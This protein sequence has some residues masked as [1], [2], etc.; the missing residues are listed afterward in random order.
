MRL[1]DEIAHHLQ[2]KTEHNIAKGMTTEEAH[3]AESSWVAWSR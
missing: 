1:D 2:A 3:R